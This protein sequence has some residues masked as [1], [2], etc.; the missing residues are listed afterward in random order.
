MGVKPLNYKRGVFLV[1]NAYDK[2]ALDWDDFNNQIETI[3]K[4]Y[5]QLLQ[6][7]NSEVEI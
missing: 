6:R 2:R 4:R 1:N 3:A 7:I 5:N